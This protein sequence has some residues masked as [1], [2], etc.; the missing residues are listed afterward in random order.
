MILE[1]YSKTFMTLLVSVNGK[2]NNLTAF[3]VSPDDDGDE[4][5]ATSY[6]NYGPGTPH[7]GP[8]GAKLF[9]EPD[10]P[11]FRG[12]EP[13]R[14]SFPATPHPGGG[15]SA[16]ALGDGGYDDEDAPQR[17]SF[18]AAPHPRGGRSAAAL[19]DSG[20]DDDALGGGGRDL[21][22]GNMRPQSARGGARGRP[23]ERPVDVYDQNRVRP[24]TASAV[25]RQQFPSRPES[26][27]PGES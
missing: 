21:G 6:K 12:N 4:D 20:Y 16:A 22:G 19:G 3:F 8:R 25:H 14:A 7:P 10:E 18:P 1:F 27:T 2:L 23:P 26:P 13:Q 24:Q 11:A 15:R 9:A 17:A 5:T